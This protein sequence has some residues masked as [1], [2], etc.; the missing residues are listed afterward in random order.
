ML[1]KLL[2]LVISSLFIVGCATTQSSQKSQWDQYKA[3]LDNKN[4][5]SAIAIIDNL[6]ADNPLENYDLII[7][8]TLNYASGRYGEYNLKKFTYWVN[9][10][11]DDID[12]V[13]IEFMVKNVKA[14]EEY[15]KRSPDEIRQFYASSLLMCKNTENL[16]K[17]LEEDI[18][19]APLYIRAVSDCLLGSLDTEE[20]LTLYKQYLININQRDNSL[21]KA[22]GIDLYLDPNTKIKN[23]DEEESEAILNLLLQI[24]SKDFKENNIPTPLIS[25]DARRKIGEMFN[26]YPSYNE[27]D[28][29]K[30][31]NLYQELIND[32]KS[33]NVDKDYFNKTALNIA[34]IKKRKD[35]MAVVMKN[36][37]KSTT[38]NNLG[39]FKYLHITQLN[40]MEGSSKEALELFTIYFNKPITFKK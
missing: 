17:T 6:I 11:G 4:Y 26:L 3:F 23:L 7:A 16:P 33:T 30:L 13:Q 24:Y 10:L 18:Y 40:S 22:H 8:H 31:M 39:Y 35:D 27:E 29:F 34:V 14:S 19:N 20:G 9:R 36:A 15:Y 32:P 21:S 37:L 1:N 38:N 28:R 2:L 25:A 12:N 5:P